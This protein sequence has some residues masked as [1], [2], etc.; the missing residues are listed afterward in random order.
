MQMPDSDS[1]RRNPVLQAFRAA[2][3]ASAPPGPE[4]VDRLAGQGLLETALA[5]LK[6]SRPGLRT[7]DPWHPFRGELERAV[8]LARQR[9]M[10]QWQL[11]PRRRTYRLGLR[12]GE[13]ICQLH[14]PALLA[15][16]ATALTEAG[17][18]L[19]AGLEKSPRPMVHLGHPL[20]QGVEGLREWADITLREAPDGPV[21][22]WLPRINACCPAGLSVLG[23][24]P[25]PNHASPVLDLCQEAQWTWLCPAD[26][27][28]AA[29]ERLTAFEAATVFEIAKTGKVG[30][31]KQLKQIDV[32]PLV[33]RLAWEGDLLRFATRLSPSE[34]LNPV[35]LLAGILGIEPAG[36]RH[37]VRER[38]VLAE[39]PRLEQAGRFE[40][41]LHNIFEDAV[42]LE[43][44]SNIRLVDEDDDEPILLG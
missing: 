37:L 4:W 36:I 22:A 20:P 9:R 8:A 32:R 24:E 43:S 42:L 21:P 25:V 29:R 12:I 27:A 7:G 2:L 35:K 40:P 34:A 18:P 38:V 41:K 23:M 13:P 17:L 30:G 16:L 14:P 39:D 28:A 19:A 11:D 10:N 6:R 1:D 26:L 33:L 15:S 3:G 44:G 5:E 31:Q